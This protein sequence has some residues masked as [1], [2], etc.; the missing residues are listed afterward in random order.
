MLKEEIKFT[1]RDFYSTFDI[2][3][4][5]IKTLA[6]CTL[7]GKYY[8]S[9]VR[10]TTRNLY[11]NLNK[12]TNFVDDIETEIIFRIPC[13]SD[14]DAGIL[15]AHVREMFSNGK[16]LRLSCDFIDN[17]IVNIKESYDEI[18]TQ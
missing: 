3:G 2:K 6:E 7:D 1:E 11:Q 15:A 14:K 17:E 10:I 13:S 18:L 8:N 16:I 12:K 5:L 4:G 9:A